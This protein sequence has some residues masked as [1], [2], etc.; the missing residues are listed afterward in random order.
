MVETITITPIWYW[1][2]ATLCKGSL[3][4]LSLS[5]LNSLVSYF[6]SCDIQTDMGY[7][8]TYAVD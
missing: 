3:D 6:L 5:K 7:I 1:M 2:K 8:Y 4:V